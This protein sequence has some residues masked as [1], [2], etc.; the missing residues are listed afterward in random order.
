ML[1]KHT[2]DPV[3]PLL[4]ILQWSSISCRIKARVLTLA[5][6]ALDWI[7]LSDLISFPLPLLTLLPATLI[8]LEHTKHSSASEPL[9]FVSF[10][11]RHLHS[12]YFISF[13]F[14]PNC[15]L[16]RDTFLDHL[17]AYP[18]TVSPCCSAI[19]FFIPLVKFNQLYC[20]FMLEVNHFEGNR[21]YLLRVY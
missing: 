11:P 14:L 7:L 2:S 19:F 9:N 1:L 20:L 5:N 21:K 16:I 8:F 12:S 18:I 13:R 10:F 3:I 17:T 4:K 6:K 15:S